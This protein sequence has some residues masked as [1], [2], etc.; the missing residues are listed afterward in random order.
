MNILVRHYDRVLLLNLEG[1][2][3]E[4]DLVQMAGYIN[5]LAT[6]LG[7]VVVDVHKAE[8][9]LNTGKTLLRLKTQY[10]KSKL[11]FLIVSPELIGAD[12][13]SLA[14]AIDKINS[15]ESARI[16]EIFAQD[17]ELLLAQREITKARA[18]LLAKLG[19]KES[20]EQPLPKDGISGAIYA[21]EEK[22]KQLLQLFKTL[23]SEIHHLQEDDASKE[24]PGSD[25]PL[26]VRIAESKRRILDIIY[27]TGLLD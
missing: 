9:D 22:N 3:L 17:A 18:E 27:G 12:T 20:A 8:L 7:S 14:D 1:T 26:A 10:E 15:T 11:R 5:T 24:M 23:S 4:A 25:N 19:L 13:A 21:L 16:T 6:R 2:V